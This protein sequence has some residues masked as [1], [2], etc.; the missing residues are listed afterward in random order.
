MPGHKVMHPLFEAQAGMLSYNSVSSAAA[1]VADITCVDA[2][3]PNPPTT[4][5]SSAL[6]FIPYTANPINVTT[7]TPTAGINQ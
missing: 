3:N 7:A 6:R 4:G 2:P 5:A 1:M